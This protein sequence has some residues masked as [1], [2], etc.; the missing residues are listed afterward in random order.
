MKKKILMMA[1]VC[2]CTHTVFSQIIKVNGGLSLSAMD[3]KNSSTLND[4]LSNPF[5]TAGLDYWEHKY[6]YL[7]SEVGFI[8]KGGKESVNLR[9]SLDD[10]GTF[11]DIKGAWSVIQLNT[12]FRVKI[13]V[14]VNHHLIIGAG[15]SLD[16][17][18]GSEKYG[19]EPHSAS[20]GVKLDAGY[21][22][23]INERFKLG[24]IYSFNRS[25]T[26]FGKY[27]LGENNG[28]NQTSLI[29]VVLGYR[30]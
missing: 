14:V 11:T 27:F 2:L 19:F 23:M 15:P 22:T 21:E 18:M 3:I 12:T 13:P 30:L 10:P 5:V 25:L 20:L 9:E 8:K 4:N 29:S 26:P 16:F 17:I 6:W 24:L 1:F 7:S 28:Y